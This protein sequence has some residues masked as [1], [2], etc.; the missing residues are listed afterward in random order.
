MSKRVL[1]IKLTSMGD[2]MHALPALTDASRMVPNIKFD[3]VVD[4]A[5]SDV[6]SWHPAV[7]NIIPS[8]HRRW[9]KNLS[10]SIFGGQLKDF[11]KRLNADDYDVILDA[12]NNLKSAVITGLR[13]GRSHGLDKFSIREKPAHWAYHYRH[14]A[15]RSLHAIARQRQLFAQ[16]IGYQVPESDPDF[17]ID[18]NRLQL[19]DL[20]L[21]DRYLVFVHNASWTTKLWP[22]SHWVQL[23]KKAAEAEYHVVLPCGNDEELQRAQRLAA[24]HDNAIALPRLS[25]SQVGA[26]LEKSSGAV[27][28]DTGLCHLAGLL[29]VPSVS[30]YGPT[31][32]ALIGAT[33][34][35]QQHLIA[36]SEI[37][38]CAPC[39]ARS[40]NFNNNN[41]EMSACMASFSPETTWDQLTSLIA[42][43]L[44]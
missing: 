11:Y 32:A 40:C 5:F 23:I 16:A 15:D 37:F 29:G 25:L 12:Q 30:F 34:L 21:P 3:W 1:L 13:R 35:N 31:S 10:Q 8:A 22:E 44:S 28:C 4:E 20:E 26:I 9:K 36:R 24:G 41:Q 17:G 27:C 7:E 42:N 33:G 6:P 18:R 43:R 38:S 19:P 39:Y 2:L 14:P